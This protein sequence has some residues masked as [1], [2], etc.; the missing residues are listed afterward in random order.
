VFIVDVRARYNKSI[1][2]VMAAWL[3]TRLS[4]LKIERMTVENVTKGCRY[5]SAK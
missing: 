3:T 4:L 5:D 2:F 1:M